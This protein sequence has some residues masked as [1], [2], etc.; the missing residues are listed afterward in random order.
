MER[1]FHIEMP[2]VETFDKSLVIQQATN[3]FHDKGYN[4]TSMQD[5]VDA[6]GLNRSS[7]YNS[8]ESKH[9]LFLECMAAYQNRYQVKISNTLLKANNPL[10]AIHFIFDLYLNE[11][12]I[13]KDKRGCMLVN[14]KSEMANHDKAIT[15]FLNKNQDQ[16]V[17]LLEDLVKKGQKENLINN[18]KT[19]KEYALYLYSSIQGF[20]M[21]GILISDKAQ[22]QS[23]IKTIIQTL[24]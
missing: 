10:E 14:C 5:L 8:F 18:I 13:D 9:N 2:K 15:N 6:T 23:I 7:I 19:Y 20:R 22:L 4:A 1:S 21:T 3:V 12:A 17:Y 16:T 11:I 24:T